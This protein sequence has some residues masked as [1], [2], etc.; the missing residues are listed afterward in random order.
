MRLL[1]PV[2]TLLWRTLFSLSPIGPFLFSFTTSI[3][4]D[5]KD[6]SKMSK[7]RTGQWCHKT[8]YIALIEN[9]L[10]QLKD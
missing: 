7:F 2:R 3:N 9:S 8:K 5:I 6:G 1:L 10:E 4:A